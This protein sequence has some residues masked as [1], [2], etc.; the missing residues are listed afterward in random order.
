MSSPVVETIFKP[1]GAFEEKMSSDGVPGVGVNVDPDGDVI[2]HCEKGERSIPADMCIYIPESS[3]Q[4]TFW[5]SW[6]HI[7]FM[8]VV[9][10][11]VSSV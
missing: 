2:S 11:H 5:F 6:S 8:C 9:W 10:F 1:S 4:S 3:G 7:S